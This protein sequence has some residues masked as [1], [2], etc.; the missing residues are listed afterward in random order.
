MRL[1]INIPYADD[2][3]VPLDA[4]GVGE[5]AM[6]VEKAGL[7]GIWLQDSLDPGHWRPDGFEWL[8]AAAATTTNIELGFAVYLVPVH[9]PVDLAQ[10]ALTLQALSNDRFTFGVGAASRPEAH[11]TMGTDFTK[12]FSKLYHDVDVIR[13]LARGEAVGEAHLNP[14]DE[15]KGG[16]RMAIGA[17]YNEKALARAA[18]EYDAWLSS[19]GRTSFNVMKKG[20]ELYRSL[21]GT[22]AIAATIFTD[23]ET[24]DYPEFD[25]D[26]PFNLRCDAKEAKRR[27]GMLADIGMDDAL[28]MFSGGANG[29]LRKEMD[30]SL[31]QL[32]ELA[33]LVEPDTTRPWDPGMPVPVNRRIAPAE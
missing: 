9:H 31:E 4:R 8:T 6:L 2:S 19:A 26:G 17:W 13:A 12:R 33:S 28:I 30:Y 3:G 27:L 1:G 22:R 11:N 25:P 23:L 15:V 24:K 16:P 7:A 21:G 10:R 14:W 18:T 32:E 5:R 20:L 29:V